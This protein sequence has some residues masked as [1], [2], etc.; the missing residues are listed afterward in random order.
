MAEQEA[1][2]ER[3]SLFSPTPA[4]DHDRVVAAIAAAELRTSGEIRILIARQ[5]AEDPVAAARSHFER[6]GMTR[7]AARNGV[8]IFVAPTSHT[9]AIVGD[10]AVHEKCGDE[11]WRDVAQAMEQQF[12]RGQFT[13][14]LVNGIERA[15]G[16]LAE[17]FPRQPDD[18]NE[19]PNRIEEH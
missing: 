15:G 14:G 17:Y 19:L 2:G 1:A 16:L 4:I 9:F 13:E 7:T 5:K 10:T 11:F 3:M 6:L 12:R 18:R 8:L